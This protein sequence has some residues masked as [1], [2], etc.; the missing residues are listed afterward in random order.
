MNYV[1]NLI[2]DSGREILQILSL[3]VCFVF[4]KAVNLS[5]I[6]RMLLGG[7]NPTIDN[8]KYYYLMLSG[9]WTIGCLISLYVLFGLFRK[10]NKATVLNR[11]NIYHNKPYF[12]YWFCSKVLGYEKCN[13]ILVPIYTQFRL[14]LRDTFV[15]YPFDEAVF[16]EEECEVIVEKNL[17]RENVS[18]KEINLI[19]QD[20]YPIS[21]S[22]IPSTMVLNNTIVVKRIYERFGKRVYCKELID[23]IVEAIRELPDNVTLNIFSTSNPKNTYE[24]VKKAIL[25]AERGNVENVNVFQQNREGKREFGAKPHKVM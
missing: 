25:L 2:L 20:T 10:S 19:I 9:N 8:A 18:S 11:G 16:P 14:I 21:E 6:I 12:W 22:Q 17:N 24:I 15:E 23:R 5:E 13:L 1:K 4:P 7:A 3:I